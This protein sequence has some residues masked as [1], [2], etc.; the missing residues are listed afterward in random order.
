M[1]GGSTMLGSK[2]SGVTAG[3]AV[4]VGIA[5]LF[6]MLTGATTP[7]ASAQP[8]APAALVEFTADG[9]LKQPVGYRKWVYIGTPV[10]PNDMNDGEASFP[11]FH[12]VYMTPRASPTTRKPDSTATAPSWLRNSAASGPRRRPAARATSR[13]SSRAW[14]SRSRTQSASRTSPVTGPILASA[15]STRSRPRWPRALS[16]LA[17]SAM[18]RTPRRRTGSSASITPSCARRPRSRSDADRGAPACGA[19]RMSHH[20]SYPGDAPHEHQRFPSADHR[21]LGRSGTPRRVGRRRFV[22]RVTRG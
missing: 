19:P 14:R 1:R 22:E 12:E 9:K 2:L 21:R 11:E 6:Y 7:P 20:L 8:K 5:G 10:T 4:L 3:V 15:T 18:S 16:P 13:A 17:T